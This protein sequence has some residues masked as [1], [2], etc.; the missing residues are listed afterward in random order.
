MKTDTHTHVSG[1]GSSDSINGAD[2]EVI[3]L[4][5]LDRL[6]VPS[7]GRP[8][9]HSRGCGDLSTACTASGGTHSLV[10]ETA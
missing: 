3:T 2:Q 6:G 4:F 5:G 1:C 9:F 7:L 10:A 8:I